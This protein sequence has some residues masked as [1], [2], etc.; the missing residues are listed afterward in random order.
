[1]RTCMDGCQP[2]QPVEVRADG[3]ELAARYVIISG[4][5]LYVDG[6]A[7]RVLELAHAVRTS[8]SP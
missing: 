7:P 6:L 5:S 4:Y 3:S 1:M 2:L 8:C